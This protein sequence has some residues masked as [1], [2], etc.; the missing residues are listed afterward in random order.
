M[1][2]KNGRPAKAGDYVVLIGAQLAI[3][4]LHSVNEQSTT[5]NG[6]IAQIRPDDPCVT[7]GNLLHV[8]DVKADD[9]KEPVEPAG[10]SLPAQTASAPE[11]D[12]TGTPVEAKPWAPPAE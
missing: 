6:R 2:Y 5:C 4:V 9:F 1:H 10:E 11:P 3:G 8:D 7:V 12:N